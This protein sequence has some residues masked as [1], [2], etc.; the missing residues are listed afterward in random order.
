M[1]EG[2]LNFPAATFLNL[3]GVKSAVAAFFANRF[4]KA[5]SPAGSVGYSSNVKE[6]EKSSHKAKGIVIYLIRGRSQFANLKFLAY[7]VC[8]FTN[9]MWSLN[10]PTY[11][12][13]ACE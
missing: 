2:H 12:V 5:Q 7:H 11:I 9:V 3:Y 4:A 6:K 1:N 10:V 13:H 8:A